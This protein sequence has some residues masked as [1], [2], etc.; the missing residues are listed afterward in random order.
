MK[1]IILQFFVVLLFLSNSLSAQSI[2]LLGSTSVSA[3]GSGAGGK[4]TL[5]WD[6]PAGQN[7][8]M[9]IHFYFERDHSPIPPNSDNY[10]SGNYAAIPFPV[11]AGGKAMTNRPAVSGAGFVSW[12]KL[13]STSGAVSA[14]NSDF[15]TILYRYTLSDADGL[16]TG[17]TTFDFSGINLPVNTSDEVAVS[18]EVYGNVSPTTP[19]T[20]AASNSWSNSTPNNVT[21]FSVTPTAAPVPAGRTTA[22]VVYVAAGATSKD[23]TLAISSGWTTINNMKVTNNVSVLAFVAGGSEPTNEGDGV[24]LLT[25]YRS[26]PATPT[27]TTLTKSTTQYLASV[28]LNIVPLLPIAKPSIAGNVYLDIDGPANIGGAGTNGGGLYLNLVD[29]SNQVV[30]SMAVPAGGAF[31]IP[32]GYATEGVTYTLQLSKNQ[33]IIGQTAPAKQ[34]NDYWTTIGEATA[35]TGNDGSADGILS[36]PAGTSNIT[37]LRFGIYQLAR[38]SI[39]GNVYI[40]TDGPAN[41]GGTGTNGGGLYV[42]AIDSNNL[43]AYSIAVTSGTGAFTIPAGIVIE[44]NTYALQLSKNQ[45]TIGQTAPVKELNTGWATVGESLAATGNDGTAD[46]II[47]GTIGTANIT[48]LRYGI[49]TD[50][51]F[52]C[53]S[54][55]YLSQ[56]SP[57]QLFRIDRSTNPFTYTAIGA[58]TAII[59]NAT[60][61][62]PIDGRMYAI[63]GSTGNTLIRINNNGTYVILGVVSGLNSSGNYNGGVI[64]TMGNYYVKD[65][66]VDN[67]IYKINIAALTATT[68]NLS[69]NIHPSDFAFNPMNGLLYGV[70]M[71]GG[72][73]ASQLFSLDPATGTVGMFGQIYNSADNFG[74]LFS[75]NTGELYASSNA[76]G[77][78]QFNVITGARVLLSSAPSSGTNDG[79][80]CILGN[81]TFN[82]DPYVTKTASAASVV[83]GS[84]ITFTVV[85]GNNGPFGVLDA[86]VTDAVPAGIPAANISYTAVAS[87]G[88]ST[89]VTGTKTG[90]INDYV[91]LP[92]GGKVTYTVTVS[93]PS[94]FTGSL[95]NTAVIT[96]PSNITDT[97]TNNNQATVS[98]AGPSVPVVSYCTKPGATGTPLT[99]SV[100]IMT[101]ESKT[102]DNWPTDVPNGYL[103]L[104]AAQKGMVITHM[105]TT[106]INAL[107]PVEGM[108]VY[109]TIEGC[110]KLYRGTSPGV[111]IT[112]T[113][114]VCIERICND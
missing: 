25:A 29:A 8:M 114:W 93:V 63:I 65:N 44:G 57:T 83:A 12:Y 78:Y 100:G 56:N 101:K 60:A 38:P 74:A 42:N 7:R 64:D 97:N 22:D 23:E 91:S 51:P 89:Q 9:I 110:V 32:T 81:T 31:T 16:P 62:N 14:S 55:L 37:G 85:A 70:D 19:F 106:Q 75:T 53:D 20:S 15:S 6:I 21:T 108:L 2:T 86:Q 43:V 76:G 3:K 4:P 28:R 41:I 35:A 11:T 90:A 69:Q 88:S 96:P 36:I 58:A 103:V 99:S 95:I 112:R 107:V 33:G 84:T 71:R 94:G 82:A 39:T 111:Q 105:T 80:N 49:A 113:G 26:F 92:V 27:A 73:T 79:A 72:P 52:N 87:S 104:D 61:I 59:Y 17:V 18:I 50:L 45:G 5:S 40:D 30:Y 68:I 109:D 98:V 34:L 48:G 67:T 66:N 1:K 47:S 102:V 54:T 24:S 77:F 10:P 46:G 13:N